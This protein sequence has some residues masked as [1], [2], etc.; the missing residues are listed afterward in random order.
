MPGG[1][2][3]FHTSLGHTVH[4]GEPSLPVDPLF[5]R[6]VFDNGV[7]SQALFDAGSDMASDDPTNQFLFLGTP[8]VDG[9][10]LA[11]QGSEIEISI[12]VPE[13]GTLALFGSALLAC[14]CGARRRCAPVR[15]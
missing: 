12:Q 11:L 1:E 13:P 15:A 4:I 8:D 10:P 14:F 2:F 5:I 3:A 7:A 6:Y 9:R